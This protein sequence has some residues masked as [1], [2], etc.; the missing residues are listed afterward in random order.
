MRRPIPIDY[1]RALLVTLA[2]WPLAIWCLHGSANLVDRAGIAFGMFVVLL[3]PGMALYGL[4]RLALWSWTLR[5]ARRVRRMRDGLCP[6]CG[7]DVRAS[8]EQCP[9]CGVR[10]ATAYADLYRS[11]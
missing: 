2:V 1:G 5:R 4:V 3:I 7:Y 10:L 11:L 9:E 6:E 8:P